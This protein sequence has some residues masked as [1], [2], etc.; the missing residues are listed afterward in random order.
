MKSPVNKCQVIIQSVNCLCS[1][2]CSPGLYKN[3]MPSA[4][5]L[6]PALVYLIIGANPHHIALNLQYIDKYLPPARRI[7]KEGYILAN[8][9]AALNF[10]QNLDSNA[11]LAG[12]V[13]ISARC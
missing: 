8:M 6:F 13:Q 10:L 3:R 5:E 12:K 11:L 7:E 1:S 4:E 2:L 9:G